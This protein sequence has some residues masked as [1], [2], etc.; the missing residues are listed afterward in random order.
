MVHPIN[1]K[2]ILRFDNSAGE[3]MYFKM[4][5]ISACVK[6]KEIVL[7]NQLKLWL[8]F[9]NQTDCSDRLPPG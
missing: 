3:R 8:W 7:K 5:E 4:F 6:N 9:Y 2:A 1:S